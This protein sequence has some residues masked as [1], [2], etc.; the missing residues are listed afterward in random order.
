MTDITPDGT[1]VRW[2]ADE[3]IVSGDLDSPAI[4]VQPEYRGGTA[5][6]YQ[7]GYKFVATNSFCNGSETM[8][9]Y[10]YVDEPLTGEILG[11]KVI[12]E[13]FNSRIDASSYSASVYKWSV[14]DEPVSNSASMVVSPKATTTYKLSMERAYVRL[15]TSSC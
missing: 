8:T 9:A 10:I 5:H 7:Y 4:T 14:D 11:D 13:T 1:T 3:T 15:R 2:V 6:Q 12:C